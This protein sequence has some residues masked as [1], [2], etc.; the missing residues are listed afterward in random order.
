[1][2]SEFVLYRILGNDL[3]PRHGGGQTLAN[4]RFILDHEPALAECEKRW[5]VNRIFDAAAEAEI[6]RFLE[7]HGQPYLHLPFDREAYA[8]RFLDATGLPP[9]LNPLAT[10][11]ASLKPGRRLATLDWLHRHKNLYAMNN[12]GARNAALDEGKTLAR[13]TLPWDGACFVTSAGWELIRRAAASAGEARY[14]IVP[15]A[16]VATNGILLDSSYS[17]TADQEPQIAFGANA[18]ERFDERLRYG[19]GPKVELLCRLDVPGS[20]DE[21]RKTVR[22]PWDRPADRCS[23]DKGLY[24]SAGWVARL[25]AASR[26]NVERDGNSRWVARYQAIIL[27]CQM[28]DKAILDQRFSADTLTCYSRLPD[29]GAATTVPADHANLVIQ[30]ANEAL[31]LTPLS[32]IDKPEPAPGGDKHDYFTPA[33]YWSGGGDGPAVRHDGVRGPETILYSPESAAYDRTRFQ[34]LVDACIALALAHRL[35]GEARYAN[36]AAALLRIWFLDPATA[37]SPHLRHAQLRRD[38]PDSASPHGIVEFRDLWPL[39]DAIRIVAGSGALNDS[40]LAGLRSW[41]SRFLDY[42]LQSPQGQAA[43]RARNNIG[44]WCDLVITSVAAFVGRTDVLSSAL[45]IAPVRFADQFDASCAQPRELARTRPAHYTLFNL[46]AW[47]NLA[48]LGH[49]VGI[50]LWRYSDSTPRSLCR[51]IRHA[52]DSIEHLPDYA[53]EAEALQRRLAA[54]AAAVPADAAEADLINSLTLP[55]GPEPL[56]HPDTGIAPFWTLFGLRH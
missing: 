55:H 28:T 8:A 3:P 31:A 25:S 32:V 30:R 20:W 23:P 47:V 22:A 4:L 6:I 38:Q 5:V 19:T 42:L 14:L 40:D 37:M 51:A 48:S 34:R 9:D 36:H 10:T 35:T 43:I 33:P 11:L 24:V 13:W 41:F 26:E 17:P 12:N 29:I 45:N 27:F 18:V 44:T 1:M 56:A 50:D 39:L 52:A 7:A 16:R 2:R 49:A 46:Q 21:W 15:M 53:A 54:L